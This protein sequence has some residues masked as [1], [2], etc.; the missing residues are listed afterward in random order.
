ME[1]LIYPELKAESSGMEKVLESFS[2]ESGDRIGIEGRREFVGRSS[3]SAQG[4]PIAVKSWYKSFLK[5]GCR[6]CSP[7]RGTVIRMSPGCPRGERFYAVR[8]VL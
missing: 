6:W 1:S 8:E 4:V 3:S 7:V 2:I 5:S